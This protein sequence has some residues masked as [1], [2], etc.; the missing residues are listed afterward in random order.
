MLTLNKVMGNLNNKAI[1]A[2][3][4]LNDAQEGETTSAMAVMGYK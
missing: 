2:P 1:A 3:L 4:K